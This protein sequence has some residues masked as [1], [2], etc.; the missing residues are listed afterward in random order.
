[1][2]TYHLNDKAS[3]HKWLQAILTLLVILGLVLLIIYL[4]K[5]RRLDAKT[6]I[7]NSTTSQVSINGA[8][9]PV[10]AIGRYLFNGTIFWGRGIEHWAQKSDG[11]YDYA[12]PFSGLNTFNRQD[13]DAWVADLECPITDKVVSFK[14]QVDNL[15]FNCR[16]EYVAEAAKYFNILD[17]ANNHTDNMGASGLTSTRTNL[18]KYSVQYFGNYDPGVADDVCK[19]MG[20]PIKVQYSDASLKTAS[21]PVA[22]CAWHYF[23]RLPRAGEIEA[24]KAVS[25]TM[26]VFA[27]VHMGVEYNTVAQ[28]TQVS[29][30]HE[31]ADQ[32][33]EFVIA[34]NPHW[35]QNIEAYKGK[36]IVYSTGNFIFDQLDSEGMRSASVDLSATIPYDLNLQK[37]LDIGPKCQQSKDKCLSLIKTTG[38]KKPILKLKYDVVAGDNSNKLTKKG[39]DQLLLALKARLNWD[40]TLKNLSK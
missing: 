27:F 37:W 35:V 16:P 24:M 12:H 32:N 28:A 15:I 14:T 7:Q 25:D 11:S 23:Y 10:T 31:V 22:F 40:Q 34:N 5:I 29:I 18:D 3:P 13:Y 9:K 19:V 33:P 36:L 17:L 38:L 20:L 8:P 39:S 6:G 1:M 4:L 30:A 26:P 21:L 2:E